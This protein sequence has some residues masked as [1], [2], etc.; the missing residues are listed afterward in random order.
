MMKRRR[1]TLASAVS[2]WI[3]LAP[4]WLGMAPPAAA[5][6][7]ANCSEITP[8]NRHLG[9]QASTGALRHGARATFENYSLW[10]CSNPG[11]PVEI[12]GSLVFSNVVPTDGSTWDIIQVGAADCRSPDCGAGMRYYYALGLASST[13][14]CAGYQS[15]PPVIWNA[16]AWTAA[17]HEYRVEHIA[18]AWKLY[19]DSSLARSYPESNVCWTPRS[20]VWFGESWDYGDQIGG[21][22]GNKL[23]ISATKY[24]TTEGGGW[25]GT[26]FVAANPCNY[27]GSF[28]VFHCDVTGATTIDIWTDR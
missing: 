12:S 25:I 13:P 23:T 10:Q 19:V 9:H 8:Q 4:A 5:I 18:N 3:A 1:T 17:A 27:A 16:G 11:F 24:T 14:G 2:L 20:S 26:S 22:L 7:T 21:T 28:D 6:G 15:I